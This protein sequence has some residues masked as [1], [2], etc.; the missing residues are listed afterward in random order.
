MLLTECRVTTV[1]QDSD[2]LEVLKL[3]TI[4]VQ[5]QLR[6]PSAHVSD[7]AYDGQTVRQLLLV[8][9]VVLLQ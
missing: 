7:G 8:L 4:L 3:L 6:G 2:L 5:V 1:V 9:V